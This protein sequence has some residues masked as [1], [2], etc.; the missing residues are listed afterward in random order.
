MSTIEQ[1]N[2]D[3]GIVGHLQFAPGGGGLPFI[4]VDNGRGK[5]LISVYAGQVL[6]F[7]PAGESDDLMFLSK[8]AYYSPGKAIKGGAPICWPWF[9]PDPEGKGRPGHG[10]VR[11]RLWSVISTEALPNGDTKVVLGLDDTP[12]TQ[13]IWPQAFELRQEITVGSE[14]TLELVTRN[15]GNQAFTITQAFHT[16]FKV[17]DI[18]QA[19]V[20]GLE[21][22]AYLD[23][24]DGGKEKTQQG[25]VAIEGEVDR[26]YM[27]VASDL[28]I[29]DAALG[30]R[31]LIQ[32][33][34]S[35]SAVVW[36][37]W[38]KI[39]AEMG[40]LEDDDYLRFLCVETTNAATDT[41]QVPPGEERRLRTVYRS[42][43]G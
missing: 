21:G 19:R 43:R 24:V 33:S 8:L 38:A 11:N 34:G 36:N 10:F 28:V 23:K 31:I 20:L 39:S 15:R 17:G 7:L 6:S 27:G 37:P 16:Y 4:E 25:A 29:D 35:Q 12:E 9:G 14:L 42:A 5:A 13:S 41:V 1:L 32:S 22:C 26:V 2:S 40:D 3:H 18:G 30:R